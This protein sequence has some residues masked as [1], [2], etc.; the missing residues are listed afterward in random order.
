MKK[1]IGF[2]ALLT[3]PACMGSGS[4]GV[5]ITPD[6]IDPVAN[7][8]IGTILNGTRTASGLE[9]LEYNSVVGRVAQDHAQDM[10]NRN[11]LSIFDQGTTG[12]AGPRGGEGDMG[13]DLNAANRRWDEIVQMVAQGDM[14]VADLN[15]EFLARQNTD[16][17][18]GDIGSK[19]QAALDTDTD[20]EFFGL[21]KAGSGSNQ[22]WAL[23]V[24]DPAASWSNR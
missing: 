7:A 24:V 6:P 3:L 20:F 10:L 22:R 21:G 9:G 19:L 8:E 2:M 23:I 17:I 16:P 12:F 14:T 15:A 13:D 1:T 18:E 4:G 11:Y 5:E